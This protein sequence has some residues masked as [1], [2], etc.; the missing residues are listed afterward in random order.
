VSKTIL[1]AGT[2]SGLGEAAVFEYAQRGWNVV[3]AMRNVAAAN[4]RFA[5]LKNTVVTNI[6]VTDRASID[7][8]LA[9]TGEK[10][11]QLDAL[12][13]VAGYGQVGAIEEV[14]PAQLRA[15]YETNVVGVL[16][17]VQAV[18]PQ[19]RARRGGHILVVGSMS[20]HLSF[21]TMTVY[22]SSKAAV[23]SLVEGLQMECEPLGVKITLVEPAGYMTKFFDNV[24]TAER[25]DAY[26]DT[27]ARMQTIFDN[28]HFGNIPKS[29]GA[30]ADITGIDQPPQHFA[31]NT[32]GLT[33]VRDTQA[34]RLAEYAK[35]EDVT[36]QTD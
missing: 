31:I 6:D 30:V 21:P 29:M 22:A 1:I 2:S 17:V 11:G 23:R 5:E 19:F 4:P 32:E 8:A 35:W 34:A 3:A 14:T 25:I 27:Y 7:A 9:L 33:W 10:F 28:A 24:K 26:D 18:L 20:A 36:K 15:E 12:L 16:N 13:N